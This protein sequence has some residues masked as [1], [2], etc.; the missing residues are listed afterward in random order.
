MISPSPICQNEIIPTN[1]STK[2]PILLYHDQ[3]F[4]VWTKKIFSFFAYNFLYVIGDESE[5]EKASAGSY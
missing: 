5:D 4:T 2:S 3:P 1:P